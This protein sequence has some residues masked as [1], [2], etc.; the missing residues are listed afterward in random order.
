M[1]AIHLE[2]LPHAFMLRDDVCV[3]L[4]REGFVVFL[5]DDV[6]G[7]V[8]E[9]VD[10]KDAGVGDGG[11]GGEDVA[12]WG[13][14]RYE[15]VSWVNGIVE[16]RGGRVGVYGAS[17]VLSASSSILGQTAGC[18]ESLAVAGRT[19]MPVKNSP[20]KRINTRWASMAVMRLSQA[21]GVDADVELHRLVSYENAAYCQRAALDEARSMLLFAE[22]NDEKR[23]YYP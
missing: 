17:E 4:G 5:V 8:I 15:C 9:H 11:E 16:G 19:S 20:H 18:E 13:V 12:V 22:T 23:T 3:A 14:T 10:C 7:D 2:H 21:G 1:V 6:G